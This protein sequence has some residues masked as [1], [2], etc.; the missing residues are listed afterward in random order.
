MIQGFFAG[1][2]LVATS[3]VLVGIRRLFEKWEKRGPLPT[4]LKVIKGIFTEPFVAL[5]LAAL[6]LAM[7]LAGYEW[8][9]TKRPD[10]QIPTGEWNVVKSAGAGTS[11]RGAVVRIGAAQGSMPHFLLAG[12]HWPKQDHAIVRINRPWLGKPSMELSNGLSIS[13]ERDSAT[14]WVKLRWKAVGDDVELTMRASSH[15][16]GWP[17][18]SATEEKPRAQ[19][20]GG[21]SQIDQIQKADDLKAAALKI[22]LAPNPQAKAKAV[23]EETSTIEKWERIER[24]AGVMRLTRED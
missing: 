11:L 19:Y 2:V 20:Y 23:E 8:I 4:W 3:L 10:Q 15:T 22:L 7:G 16:I 24:L 18:S 14:G 6:V 13:W 12:P 1:L 17:V 21:L 5:I 9:T